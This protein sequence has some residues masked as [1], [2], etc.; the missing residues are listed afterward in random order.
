MQQFNALIF[1]KIAR[2]Y[3]FR[4]EGVAARNHRGKHI[5]TA[6]V[7]RVRKEEPSSPSLA[8]TSIAC[9]GG[10][11]IR[12]M[13]NPEPSVRRRKFFAYRARAI[14]RAIINANHFN[15]AKRLRRQRDKHLNEIG[16]GVVNRND[17]GNGYSFTLA[18]DCIGNI[19]RPAPQYDRKAVGTIDMTP[20]EMGIAA[21]GELPGFL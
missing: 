17:Y 4:I 13:Q 2:C 20:P 18:D 3:D 21:G 9:N 11:G 5:R 6:K 10:P 15:V 7:V 14:C 16:F 1:D 19:K 12:L 8:N